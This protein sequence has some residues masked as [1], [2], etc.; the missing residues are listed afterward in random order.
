MNGNRVSFQGNENVL[1]F[2]VVMVV[3]L[4]EHPRNHLKWVK[5]RVCGLYLN[6]SV[7]LNFSRRGKRFLT[8]PENHRA[9]AGEHRGGPRTTGRQRQRRPGPRWALYSST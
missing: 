1:K 6:R 2:T 9:G 4:C 7:I 3:Q 8:L 5:H